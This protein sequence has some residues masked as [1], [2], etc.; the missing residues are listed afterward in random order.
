M[1]QNIKIL[2]YYKRIRDNSEFVCYEENGRTCLTNGVII[3][4][5]WVKKRY[6]P[7]C[8]KVNEIDVNN[9]IKKLKRYHEYHPLLKILEREIKQEGKEGEN[10]NEK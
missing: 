10:D 5:D 4:R 7:Q 6:L 9:I 3:W 8:K 2:G 1:K